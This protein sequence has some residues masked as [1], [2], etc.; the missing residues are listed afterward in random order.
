MAE[1]PVNGI[2]VVVFNEYAS[3]TLKTCMLDPLITYNIRLVDV[4]LVVAAASDM[5]CH[6]G[7]AA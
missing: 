2:T 7:M 4:A 6:I 5:S 3:R 1:L